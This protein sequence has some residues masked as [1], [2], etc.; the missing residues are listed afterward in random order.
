MF[1]HVGII[2]KGEINI[3]ATQFY[4]VTAQRKT[5]AVTPVRFNEHEVA[6]KVTLGGRS[7]LGGSL[8][9]GAPAQLKAAT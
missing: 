4:S 6:L 8:A 3:T 1:G 7:R 5:G 9:C 2:G